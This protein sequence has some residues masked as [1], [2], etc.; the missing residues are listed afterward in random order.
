MASERYDVIV[1]VHLH[2]AYDLSKNEVCEVVPIP[3]DKYV[4][5]LEAVPCGVRNI[6]NRAWYDYTR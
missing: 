1:L 6:T 3:K 2:G 4:T 5:F